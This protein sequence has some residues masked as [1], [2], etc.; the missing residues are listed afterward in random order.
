MEKYT[1]QEQIRRNSLKELISLG[2]NPYPAEEFKINTNSEEIKDGFSE[3]KNNFQN[4]LLAGRIMSRRI[5]GKAAFVELKDFEGRI[6][7]YFNRDEVCPGDDKTMYNVVFKKLLDIGDI[8]GVLGSVFKTKVGET[9]VRVKTFT[10]LSKA[11]KPLPIVKT[12]SDGITYDAFKNTELRYRQ[13]SLDLIVNDESWKTFETR[14]KLF[15]TIRQ[16]LNKEGYIEVETPILQPIVGGAA[17]RPFSTHHNT[18][19]IPLYLRIANELYLKRLIVGGKE[20]VFEFAKDFRN[21]GMDKTHN[22]EFT[23]LE[24]YVAYKDYNWMMSFIENLFEETIKIVCGQTKINYDQ[25]EIDF[26][27]PY[28][29]LPFFDAIKQETGDDVSKMS[30]EELVKYCKSKKIET[31]KSMG[32]GKLFDAIFGEFCEEKLIQPTYITNYPVEMS[33]LTKKHRSEEGLTERFELFINGKEI[34]NA[35]SEQN[36]PIAQRKSFENQMKLSERGDDEAMI[37]DNQFLTALEYGMPPTSGIG[38]GMDRL[39]MLITNKTSI[40]DVLFFPQ[41]KPEKK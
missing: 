35:Y 21:E 39:T 14:T 34:A 23:M 1:E 4:V 13:R 16:R 24:F 2:I 17:A 5:M 7:L 3:D 9:S 19:D 36:N 25:K 31:N 41:M 18:L 28:K 32:K 26:K 22:P 40:Q 27:G 30:E 20:G 37:I 33:P 12:D 11:I 10:L 8:I 29:K 38:I 6:Q 15:N